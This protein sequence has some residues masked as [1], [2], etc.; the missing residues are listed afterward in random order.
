MYGSLPIPAALI[1]YFNFWT[2]WSR[3]T[4]GMLSALDFVYVYNPILEEVS[5]FSTKSTLAATSSSPRSPAGP[6]LPSPRLTGTLQRVL[7]G[8]SHM[9]SVV[10]RYQSHWGWFANTSSVMRRELPVPMRWV[11]VAGVM[12]VSLKDQICARDLN[13]TLAVS[14]NPIAPP[15]PDNT[16][17]NQI[18]K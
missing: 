4:F 5:F 3:S 8:G 15:Q 1:F 7:R 14:Q 6:S 17:A 16:G 11:H 18:K 13:R 9:S 2:S 12:L 10:L